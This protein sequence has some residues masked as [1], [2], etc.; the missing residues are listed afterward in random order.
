MKQ[1][2][3]FVLNWCGKIWHKRLEEIVAFLTSLMMLW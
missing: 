2:T 3:I 1:T